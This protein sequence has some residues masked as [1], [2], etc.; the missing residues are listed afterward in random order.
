M[1]KASS[2]KKIARVAAASGAK[3]ARRQR[4]LGFAGAL[5][6]IVIVGLLLVVFARNENQSASAN[7][8]QP[9]AQISPESRGDHWHA[10]FAIDIC[11]QAQPAAQDRVQDTLGIHT[12]GD[13]VMHIHPFATRAAGKGANLGRFFDQVG[14]KV[15]DSEI[16]M[17]DAKIYREG[18]TT[19]GGKAGQVVVAHW[20]NGLKAAATK[21][22]KL[23]TSGFRSI[24]LSE[25]YGAYT[26]AFRPKGAKVEAPASASDL[27]NLGAADGGGT[28]GVTP[29]TGA[30]GG[31]STIPPVAPQSGAGGGT[32]NSTSS[33]P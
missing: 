21:P 10:A 4:N 7:D 9:R 33:K 32:P 31:Q 19:C 15:T 25:N 12:H 23:F 2:A 24:R 8:L 17:P 29:S 13:G 28:A 5:A 27:V 30:S 18:D 1:G 20:K 3:R 14:L 26:V 6:G 16:R 11:G 22:D